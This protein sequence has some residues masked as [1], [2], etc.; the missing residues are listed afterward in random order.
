ME[1]KVLKLLN[2]MQVVSEHIDVEM[3]NLNIHLPEITVRHSS[4]TIQHK[5]IVKA[6]EKIREKEY[7][8]AID[9]YKQALI[10]QPDSFIPIYNIAVLLE[11]EKMLTYSKE[12]FSLAK[13][14]DTD[15]E[16]VSFGLALVL[17][18]QLNF[19]AALK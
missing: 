9:C 16:K 8:L 12:W 5:W 4:D 10:Q 19:S 15:I 2:S 7:L 6:E 11:K 17:V 14:K 18:K 1:E 13:E 3:A